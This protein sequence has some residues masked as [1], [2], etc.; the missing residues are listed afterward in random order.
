MGRS[1]AIGL[2]VA[3]AIGGPAAAQPAAEA[4]LAEQRAAMAA[5]SFLDGEW[6][7]PAII[8]TPSG[9]LRLTQTERVGSLLDGTIKLVEGRGYDAE[10]KTVFNAFAVISYD[11][12]ADAYRFRSYAQGHSGDADF[13]K[14]DDGL[15]WSL[16]A[17]PGEM[18]FTATV[19]DG[20]WREVGDF[21]MPGQPPRRTIDMTLR[22]KGDGAWP[23]AG[24][25]AP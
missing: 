21:V 15:A 18:R 25:V 20:V 19:K 6:V 24:A 17:G 22:R 11:T 4:M 2:A 3:A 1:M 16:Q 12:V 14:T 23:A 8:P 10:G 9:E 7:G 13:R 5:L